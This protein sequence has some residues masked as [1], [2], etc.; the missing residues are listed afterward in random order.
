MN[1]RGVACS[2]DPAGKSE[3]GEFALGMDHIGVPADQFTQ[4]PAGTMDLDPGSGV[5][6]R[7]I[8][9]TDKIDTVLRK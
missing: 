3:S 9:R 5:D 2:R 8:D 6:H 4:K 1:K 7:S